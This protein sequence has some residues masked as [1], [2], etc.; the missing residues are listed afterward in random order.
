MIREEKARRQKELKN[1]QET[2]ELERAARADQRV[3]F[4]SFKKPHEANLLLLLVIPGCYQTVGMFSF[5]LAFGHLFLSVNYFTTYL[6]SAAIT[7]NRY[8]V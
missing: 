6:G 2:L 8:T 4:Q 1:L 3:S 7:G 5:Y